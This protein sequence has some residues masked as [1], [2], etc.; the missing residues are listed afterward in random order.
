MQVTVKLEGLTGVLQT[1]RG[2]PPALVSKKGGVVL[3]AL[4]RG[5]KVVDLQRKRNLQAAIAHTTDPDKR[6]STGLLAKSLTVSR[7]KQ[8]HGGKG[9]RILLRVRRKVYPGRSGSKPTTSLATANLLEYGSSQQPAEP[10]I[11]PALLS[12][13]EEAIR[14]TE[15]EL[16]AGLDKVVRKLAAANKGK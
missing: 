4:R 9:E 6:A 15:R 13:A 12:R 14:T 3:A 10:W 7:G 8:P 5:A 2:L 11:R 16:V 1:L